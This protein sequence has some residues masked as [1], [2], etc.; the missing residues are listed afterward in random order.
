MEQNIFYLTP[1]EAQETVDNFAEKINEGLNKEGMEILNIP[2]L[3][4]PNPNY[5]VDITKLKNGKVLVIDWG[6]TNFRAAIVEFKD[7]QATIVDRFDPKK[8]KA[9]YYEL[10]AK[11]ATGY[12]RENLYSKM[13]GWI[14]ELEKLDS[15]VKHIGYCFSYPAAARLNGD[16]VLLR[17]T[18]GMDIPGMVG[19]PV[20]ELL[21]NYLNNKFAERNIKFESIKVINDTIAC[22]FAGFRETNYDNYIGLIVGTGTNMA[23]LMPLGKIR[24]LNMKSDDL[25]PVN[26]ESG[27][28]NPPYLTIIDKMVDAMSNNKGS[29]C[30]EK[31]VSGGYLA[32]V[33]QT[34]FSTCLFSRKFDG[35]KM[36]DMINNPEDYK[37]KEEQVKVAGWIFDRSAKFVAASIAGLVKVL[38]DQRNEIQNVCLAAD[39][40]VFWGKDKNKNTPYKDKVEKELEIL[41]AGKGV[42]VTIIDEMQDP[43]LIGAAIA[44]LI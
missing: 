38:K 29:Q 30:F 23:S 26:L 33:F 1:E 32:E 7:G 22:L 37:G 24:K 34:V 11:V 6:G 28:F 13:A 36:A 42:K 2:T 9:G 25:I 4:I 44:A 35:G 39:G 19:E 27:N 17:W 21:L 12:S 31:A 10:S 5:P 3:H 43:N 14:G 8:V 20:G 18:K 16:A 41:L 15:T 40:S